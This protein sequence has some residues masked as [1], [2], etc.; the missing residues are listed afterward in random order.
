[1]R[2]FKLNLCAFLLVVS[3]ATIVA[4]NEDNPWLFSVGLS[5]VDF[6]PTGSHSDSSGP[7]IYHS[8]G[9]DE[10][11]NVQDHWNVGLPYLSLGRYLTKDVSFGLTGTYNR[12]K[13]WGSAELASELMF[14]SLDGSFN[15]SF[16]NLLK[17]KKN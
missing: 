15:Y 2:N 12:I 8:G 17:S 6:Y 14:L 1:M 7:N 16:A 9:L 5:A 13:K 3:T 11:F 4:Q 10:F